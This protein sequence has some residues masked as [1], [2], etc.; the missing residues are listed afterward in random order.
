MIVALPNHKDDVR[1]TTLAPPLAGNRIRQGQWIMR[2]SAHRQASALDWSA[3]RERLFGVGDLARGMPHREG[4]ERTRHSGH[5]SVDG[6]PRA[7][8]LLCAAEL[9]PVP[10][11]PS[12]FDGCASAEMPALI[13]RRLAHAMVAREPARGLIRHGPP[14]SHGKDRPARQLRSRGTAGQGR[15]RAGRGIR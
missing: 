3:R 11:Q 5:I 4:S 6:P 14:G 13:F 2:I 7:V 1:N 15:A 9:A 10:A 8:G 12:P